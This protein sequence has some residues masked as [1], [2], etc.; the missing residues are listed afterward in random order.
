MCVCVYGKGVFCND[1]L[2][3]AWACLPLDP[4]SS[5]D[6]LRERAPGSRVTGSANGRP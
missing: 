1:C 4:P 5:P 2:C 3:W 6:S